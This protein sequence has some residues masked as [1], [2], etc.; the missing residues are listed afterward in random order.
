MATSM[1]SSVSNWAMNRVVMFSFSGFLVFVMLVVFLFPN[2]V[3]AQ[4]DTTIAFVGVNVVPMDT[5]EVLLDQTVITQNGLITEVG[6]KAEVQVPENAKII[7]GNGN[8]LMPGLADMHVHLYS[9][10]D[11]DF[12]QLFLAEGVTTIGNL[13][14]LPEHLEWKQEVISGERIGPTIY[15]TGP[16]IIGPPDITFVIKYWVFIR[17]I[18]R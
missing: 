6:P 3:S 8:Y 7:A 9:D 15:T 1:K 13:S 10:P 12:M 2:F 18:F 14:G 11:P 4:E 5:E 17:K 16:T